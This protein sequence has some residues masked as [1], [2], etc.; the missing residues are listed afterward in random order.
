MSKLE[1]SRIIQEMNPK[2]DKI[3][4]CSFATIACLGMKGTG[5]TR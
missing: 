3:L 4:L 2:E 1:Q 5:K